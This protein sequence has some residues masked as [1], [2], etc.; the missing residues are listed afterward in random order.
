MST[1]QDNLL[2]TARAPAAASGPG[3][4]K[5]DDATSEET[6]LASDFTRRVSRTVSMFSIV[7]LG[8]ITVLSLRQAVETE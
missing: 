7:V 3:A 5:H 6:Y 4:G 8:F 1:R 2:K